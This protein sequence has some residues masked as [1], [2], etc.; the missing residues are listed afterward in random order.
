MSL[1]HFIAWLHFMGQN[2]CDA[3]KTARFMRNIVC[4]LFVLYAIYMKLI[5]IL[6][7]T[8]VCMCSVLPIVHNSSFAGQNGHHFADDIFKDI[9]MNEN[10]CILTVLVMTW[11]RTGDKSLPELIFTQFA[12]AY[13]IYIYAVL[14]VDEL[15]SCSC[16]CSDDN[17]LVI[18]LIFSCDQAALRT[19]LSVRPSVC[20]SFCL[21]VCLSHFFHYVSVIVSS[22]NF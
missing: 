11:H 2:L 13:I 1:G 20:P 8:Y 9:F 19:P 21:S 6:A 14:G 17:E 10:L 18:Q 7:N 12:D 3:W 16:Y 15:M 4:I 22:R 5:W